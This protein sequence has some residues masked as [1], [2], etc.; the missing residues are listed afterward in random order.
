MPE[1]KTLKR[2]NRCYQMQ[3]NSDWRYHIYTKVAG[4]VKNPENKATLLKIANEEHRH[5]Q[6]L[7]DF[8]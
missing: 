3:Q 4:F 1:I 8:Y 7:G 5:Y 2:S 6:D